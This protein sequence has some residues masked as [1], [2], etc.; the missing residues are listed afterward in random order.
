MEQYQADLALDDV[1]G[2]VHSALSPGDVPAD[3]RDAFANHITDALPNL[4]I[5][6]DTVRV[7]ALIGITH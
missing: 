6:T 1:L 7:H 2:A 4:G 3:H 5:F